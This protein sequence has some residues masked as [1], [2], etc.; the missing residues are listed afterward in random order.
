MFYLSIRKRENLV[1]VRAA[2][3]VQHVPSTRV[4]AGKSGNRKLTRPP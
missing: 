1:E 4:P 3:D 2:R